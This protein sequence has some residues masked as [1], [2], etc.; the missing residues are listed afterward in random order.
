V[1]ELAGPEEG[2]GTGMAASL[3]RRLTVVKNR[4]GQSDAGPHRF[5]IASGQGLHVFPRPAAYLERWA[6]SVLWQDWIMDEPVK[7]SWSVG[8]KVNPPTWPSFRGHVTAVHG[9]FAHMVS[10]V[11]GELGHLDCEAKP[12]PGVRLLIDFGLQVEGALE[13][14]MYPDMQFIPAGNPYLSGHR[15]VAWVRD[16]VQYFREQGL[17][18]EKVL[19]GDLRSIRSF[20]NPEEIR[21]AVAVIIAMLRQV[22]IPAVLFETVTPRAGEAEPESVD[23]ADTVV[24]LAVSAHLPIPVSI[25]DKRSGLRHTWSEEL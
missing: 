21:M 18:L 19:I 17:I 12:F 11:A 24:A 3:E 22:R 15:L 20:R 2:A 16:A 10:R 1:L 9:S 14:D 13:G 4:F 6:R 23:F 8:A 5:T 7:Q 25:T